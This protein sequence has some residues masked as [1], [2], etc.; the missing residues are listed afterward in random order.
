VTDRQTD[1]ITISKTAL[2]QLLRAV[3]KPYVMTLL[4][5]LTTWRHSND[6]G[7]NNVTTPH[8]LLLITIIL[9]VHNKLKDI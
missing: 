4:S 2:A 1:R 6:G 5:F 7:N 8:V 9:S 3:I